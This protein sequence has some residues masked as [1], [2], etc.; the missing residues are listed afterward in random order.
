MKLR[1]AERYER[2]GCGGPGGAVIGGD[3]VD[4]ERRQG[5]SLAS[6]GG[7]RRAFSIRRTKTTPLPP[8]SI[9]TATTTSTTRPQN[10]KIPY[11]K[12]ERQGT[13]LM[14]AAGCRSPV[15]VTHQAPE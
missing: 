11:R 8:S 7:V 3:I 13:N 2:K 15:L 1:G 14:V 10:R 9:E 6:G 5:H 4:S 12:T